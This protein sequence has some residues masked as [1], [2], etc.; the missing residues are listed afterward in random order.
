MGTSSANVSPFFPTEF[1][2]GRYEGDVYQMTEWQIMVHLIQ[3]RDLPGSDINPYIC[4]QIAD[5]KRYTGV[6]KCSNA[7]FF[8]EVNSCRKTNTCRVTRLLLV[9]LH[10]RLHSSSDTNAREDDLLPSSSRQ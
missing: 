5:E 8:G 9:V 3:A 1:S 7:P 6:Q 2:L 10:I 4:V